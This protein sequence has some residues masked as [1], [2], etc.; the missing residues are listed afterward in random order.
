MNSRSAERWKVVVSC[1]ES[2]PS[3][4]R[5]PTAPTL[6][7]PQVV[8]FDLGK[9][10]LDFDFNKAARA[11]AG[12]SSFSA[13]QVLGLINQTPLLHRYETGLMSTQEFFYEVRGL[14]GYRRTLPE[15]CRQ[16]GDIFSEV[17]LMVELNRYF[18]SQGLPTY[19]FSNTSELAVDH[20]RATY[21]FFSEFTGYILSYEHHVMKP[22]PQLYEIV[23]RTTGAAGGRILYFDDRAENIETAHGRGWQVFLHDRPEDTLVALRQLGLVP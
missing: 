7:Q 6:I 2:R 9:V 22:D 4:E 5:F 10:L 18:R 23:E 19:I 16:L 11:L 15:F 14:T 20:I 17:A 3:F 8:V 21:P 13:D 1:S 12:D